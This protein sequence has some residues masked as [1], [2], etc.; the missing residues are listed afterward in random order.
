MADGRN[1]RFGFG[2]AGLDEN[3]AQA[4]LPLLS[5]RLHVMGN[6]EPAAVDFLVD[7]GDEVVGRGVLAIHPAMRGS[8]ARRYSFGGWTAKQIHQAV[9]TAF[10]LSDR[11]YGLNQLRYDLRKLKGHGLLERDGSRYAYRLTAKG[12][13]WRCYSCSSINASADRLPIAVSTTNPTPTTVQTADSKPPYHRAD[14]AIQK[15]VDVL[16]A[17]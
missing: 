10:R 1:S 17:A 4:D 2:P 8:P 9:L 13:K 16:A 14:K 5:L 7:V 15:I 11:N 12:S 3:V 6:D